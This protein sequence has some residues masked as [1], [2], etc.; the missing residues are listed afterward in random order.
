MTVLIQMTCDELKAAALA[1]A[2]A[3]GANPPENARVVFQ[4]FGPD[5]QTVGG[6]TSI[7]ANI[8][9]AEQEPAAAPVAALPA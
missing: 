1:Y 7:A 5:V 2:N 3:N 8:V 6:I 4:C 9:I